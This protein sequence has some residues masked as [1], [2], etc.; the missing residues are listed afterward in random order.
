MDGCQLF[1]APVLK[2]RAEKKC[3]KVLKIEGIAI[4][5]ERGA[6]ALDKE[7]GWQAKLRKS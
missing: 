7:E 3:P 5:S 2:S 4:Q 1:I 6:L